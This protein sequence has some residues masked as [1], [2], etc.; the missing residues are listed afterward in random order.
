[1]EMCLLIGRERQSPSAKDF[2]GDVF[3]TWKIIW[4]R[5]MENKKLKMKMSF[6]ISETGCK[7]TEEE[8]ELESQG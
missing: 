4:T 7:G 2:G 5:V 6:P 8:E 1:M 3:G